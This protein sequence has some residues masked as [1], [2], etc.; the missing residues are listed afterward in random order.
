MLEVIW[1]VSMDLTDA[2]VFQGRDIDR[3]VCPGSH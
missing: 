3:I 1:E 2:K